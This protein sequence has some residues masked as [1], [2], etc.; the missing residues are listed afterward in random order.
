MRIRSIRHRGLKQ[1]WE[2]NDVSRLPAARVERIRDILTALAVTEKLRD[3]PALPGWRLH[4]LKGDRKGQWSI[5]VTGNWRI[6]FE[7][8]NGEICN[9]DLEDYH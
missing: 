7:I 9:L 8:S 1:F 3:L 5:T 2:R 4:P 6:T